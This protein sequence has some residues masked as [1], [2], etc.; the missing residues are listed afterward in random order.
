LSELRKLLSGEQEV[1][2]T[3]TDKGAWL[4]Q[5]GTEITIRLVEGGFPDYQGVVSKKPDTFI[6]VNR[7]ALIAALKRAS[8]FSSER[9]RGVKLTLGDNRSP[10]PRPAPTLARVETVG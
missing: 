6:T 8:L 5:A 9:Y 10:S 2:L 7:A 3:I 1:T 4:T